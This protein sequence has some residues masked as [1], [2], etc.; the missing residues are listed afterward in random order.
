MTENELRQRLEQMTNDVPSTTHQ[1]FAAAALSGKEKEV[2]TKRITIRMVFVTA[3]IILLTIT[4]A[5]AATMYMR[6]QLNTKEH[7]NLRLVYHWDGAEVRFEPLTDEYVV[8][9]SY[10][11]KWVPEGYKLTHVSEMQY[12]TQLLMYDADEEHAALTLMVFRSNAGMDR[13][14]SGMNIS[15]VVSEEKV[16]VGSAEA[17][18]YT[19]PDYGRCLAW[20]D[21]EAG[22]GFFMTVGD[23][24]VDLLRIAESVVPDPDLVPTE[25]DTELALQL[26]GD[27]HLTALPVGY[28]EVERGGWFNESEA[29]GEVYTWYLNAETN[30]I[31]ELE[32]TNNG[33]WDADNDV[34]AAYYEESYEGAVIVRVNG[35]TGMVHG[36]K[37]IWQD[38]NARLMFTIKAKGMSVSDLVCLAESVSRFE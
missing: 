7:K 5:I 23:P 8:F 3:V 14:G 29:R 17:T 27:Y 4:T 22:F 37:L 30:D 12:G 18:L 13:K 31:I 15:E 26:F 25:H 24:S 32:F 35:M 9:Q 38:R 10:R 19:T 28:S 20:V 34:T 1:A 2:M 33:F 36:N 16:S 11:P 6:I 21:D